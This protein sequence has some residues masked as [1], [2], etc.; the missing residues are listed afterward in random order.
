MGRWRV[1]TDTHLLPLDE[2]YKNLQGGILSI[3][4]TNGNCVAK[5]T[6]NAW[7]EHIVINYTSAYAGDINPFR[8]RGYY[9]DNRS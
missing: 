8:Y 4:D 1:L 3:N 2:L 5:Y 9:Y 6:Y 7:G